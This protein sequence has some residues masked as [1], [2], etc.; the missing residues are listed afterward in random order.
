MSGCCGG[1]E[2][3]QGTLAG[4]AGSSSVARTLPYKYLFKYIIVGDTAV[5][6]SC[7]LLQ[8]TDKRFQAQHDL[9]IG[10][11]FGSRTVS[12][13]NN[14]VKL[15]IWD[16][17]GQEKFRSITRSYYR[18]AAGALLVYDIT[19]R[20]TF[21]HLA[22]WLEDCLKYSSPNIVIMLI[23]NKSDLE[24]QRQVTRDEG[25]DFAKKHGLFFLETSAKT[26]DNVD[27]A[28][29]KTARDIYA[30]HEKGE[31]DLRQQ[32]PNKF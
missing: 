12:I 3:S 10:V 26:A 24:A 28:F 4:S 9:T 16:T 22:T 19:R 8:F 21:E 30:R 31:L 2:G 5:G 11:E 23:G 14:Q 27:E 1:G 29:I 13:D 25:A 7:L 20:D 17:A 15:Q 18:G 32:Q 6:K